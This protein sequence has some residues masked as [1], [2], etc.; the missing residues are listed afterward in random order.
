MRMS[1]ITA[2]QLD[3]ISCVR[4]E[5]HD[6]LCSAVD[7]NGFQQKQRLAFPFIAVIVSAYPCTLLPTTVPRRIVPSK[8]SNEQ[9]TEAQSDQ[10][11]ALELAPLFR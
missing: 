1:S 7:N 10:L 3:D 8:G 11:A 5:L 2:R 4:N 6:L 9:F